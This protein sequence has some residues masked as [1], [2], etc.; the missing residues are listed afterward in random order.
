MQR[1]T[2]NRWWT[3]YAAAPRFS[4]YSSSLT[5]QTLTSQQPFQAGMAETLGASWSNI[6]ESV[7][8]RREDK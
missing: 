3:G 7:D 6:A 8:Q 5:S 2:M 4:M 1:L